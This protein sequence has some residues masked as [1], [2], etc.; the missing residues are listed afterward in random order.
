MIY[1]NR[2]YVSFD[3]NFIRLI[4]DI[5]KPTDKLIDCE[6]YRKE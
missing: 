4:R 1:K 2:G 3:R 6:K 5:D